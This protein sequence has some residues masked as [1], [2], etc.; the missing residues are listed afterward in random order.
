MSSASIRKQDDG[1]ERKNTNLDKPKEQMIKKKHV[2]TN[3]DVPNQHM[4][5]KKHVTNSRTCK[6]K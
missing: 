2:T 1:K 3:L 6:V 5:N 4:I